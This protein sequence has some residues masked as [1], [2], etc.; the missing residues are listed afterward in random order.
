MLRSKWQIQTKV[1]FLKTSQFL[2]SYWSASN[3]PSPRF[4][5]SKSRIFRVRRTIV[6]AGKEKDVKF[7]FDFGNL[8]LFNSITPWVNIEHM[9]FATELKSSRNFLLLCMNSIRVSNGEKF[10]KVLLK[11]GRQ[12]EMRQQIDTHVNTDS[13]AGSLSNVM[14]L[15]AELKQQRYIYTYTHTRWRYFTSSLKP[16]PT[17]ID[18][19]AQVRLQ[20]ASLIWKK[21]EY[22]LTCDPGY[23]TEY[24]THV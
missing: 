24:G 14:A 6:I 1:T 12:R 7:L 17:S 2:A 22:F 11:C 3:L 5:I 21:N 13:F 8:V 18:G 15:G 23:F 20:Y 16:K 10:F 19:P 4:T 9:K